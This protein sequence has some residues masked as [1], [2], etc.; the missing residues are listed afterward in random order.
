MRSSNCAKHDTCAYSSTSTK[1]SR[2]A[3]ARPLTTVIQQDGC[4]GETTVVYIVT[5]R[6]FVAH[7]LKRNVESY[8]Q[9]VLTNSVSGTQRRQYKLGLVDHVVCCVN[10]QSEP[11]QPNYVLPPITAGKYQS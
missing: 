5:K 2:R 8:M 10:A 9:Q 7:N 4:C 11:R 1:N 3:R 6:W